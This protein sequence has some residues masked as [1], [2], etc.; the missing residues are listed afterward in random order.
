LPDQDHHDLYAQ[1]EAYDVA[2]DFR[3]LDNEC[4]ALDAIC[5]K[6]RGVK[7]ASFVDIGCGPG[8]HCIHYAKRGLRTFGIE[9][10][11]TML[12]YAKEKAKRNAAAVEFILTDMREFDLPQPVDLAFC[13]IA[14]IH[15][16]LSA[17][18]IINH[19]RTVAR[20]L[21]SGGL[22]VIEA[23]HPRD[24]FNVGESTHNEW[25]ARRGDMIVRSRWG[26]DDLSFDPITQICRSKVGI[27]VERD[28][29]I[30]KME[31]AHI[32]RSLTYQELKLLVGQSGVFEAVDWL[33]ILDVDKPFDN[34]KEAWRMIPVLRKL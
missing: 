17:E 9:I 31:F 5:T 29:V 6:Y 20:N 21:A 28:D 7:P 1:A 18:D 19:L 2:F 22:Y 30:E 32:D 25:E 23:N 8:Y 4:D 33:G 11:P 3:D 16:L 34:T 13:A 24:T 26:L 15:Y 10:N 12:D 14:S 27:E